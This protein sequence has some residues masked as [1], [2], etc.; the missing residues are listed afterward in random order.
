M[1][2]V[3]NM[4]PA[5]RRGWHGRLELRYRAD[6][7]R[8]V[9]H[10]LHHGPLRVLQRLYPEG[11]RICHH[12]LVHPPGGLVGGDTLDIDID[13]AA[14][15]HALVT[16]PGATR[17]Y[18]SA[19][20]D[21]I[22]SVAARLAPNARLEWLPL[23]TIA[24]RGARAANRM[25]FTLEAGAQMLGWDLLA[26]GLPAGGQAFDVGRYEQHLELP[27]V[28]LERGII[29]C[30]DPLSRRLLESPLGWDGQTTLATLWC[31]AG[32]D[33][34]EPL[35]QA[36]LESAR[37]VLDAS[38]HADRSAATSPDARVIVVR[39]LA[40]RVE[41]P[42]L[43]FQAIRHAWRRLLWN[44]DESSPRVWRT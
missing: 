12:V 33:W 5:A 36:L 18:R 11:P 16:T 24:Y 15:T 10:D 17:F 2:P 31:A 26:L 39:A 27:G 42:W 25:R 44:L 34:P 20:D 21:A 38:A 37:Q 35:R 14:E 32:S 7:G 30:A 3:T 29:D 23:E 6:A 4:A 13:L 28:W 9:G 43:S 8:T 19:G 40:P 22:Q 41:P 1:K